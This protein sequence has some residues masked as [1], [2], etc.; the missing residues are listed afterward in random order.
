MSIVSLPGFSVHL[1]P[2]LVTI[3]GRFNFQDSAPLEEAVQT[4]VH[5]VDEVPEKGK[6]SV[7]M[8]L[9]YV[10]TWAGKG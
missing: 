3:A 9:D 4:I 2:G 5:A 1:A 7:N 8:Y 10:C 6:V